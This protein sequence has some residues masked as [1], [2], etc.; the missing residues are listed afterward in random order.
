[1]RFAMGLC[2][3]VLVAALPA[4]A[5]AGWAGSR[6]ERSDC[7]LRT[8]GDGRPALGCGAWF[9]NLFPQ[10]WQLGIDDPAC[11]SGRRT[12]ERD[13]IM[14]GTYW[15]WDSYSGPAPLAKFM[16]AGNEERHSFRWVSYTDTDLGCA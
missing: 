3:A 12:I 11:P 4:V 13:G 2:I 10:T 16:I 15:G 1:M 7:V 8:A 6:Y 5:Q 9:A 14:E